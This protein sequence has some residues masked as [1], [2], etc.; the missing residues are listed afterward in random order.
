MKV[1]VAGTTGMLGNAVFKYLTSAGHQVFGLSRSSYPVASNISGFGIDDIE[2]LRLCLKEINPDVVINCIGI[3]KQ[4]RDATDTSRLYDVN[5]K[6]PIQLGYLA[7]EQ[8]FKLI[9]FSTDCV[10]SGRQGLYTE[11][12]VPDPVDDYGL[13]KL[14]GEGVGAD[15]L[16]LRT[17]IIGRGLRKNASLIDWFLAQSGPVKGYKRAIFSGL[18]VNEI[19]KILSENL[20]A[21]CSLSGLYHLSS[22]PIDKYSL[23]SLVKLHWGV[24][25]EIIED[26]SVEIDRS[27][28]SDRLQSAIGIVPRDWSVMIKRMHEFYSVPQC[29]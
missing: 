9:H 6:Y 12:D 5:S 20:N 23:L 8:K 19:G 13:S 11:T 16:V 15:G 2:A 21:V 24:R 26:N 4:V 27:L 29:E 22:S 7:R 17:S 28:N 1:V 25:T 14:F 3:I 18:P 10:F